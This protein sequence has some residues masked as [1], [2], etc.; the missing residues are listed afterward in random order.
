M[1]D[2]VLDLVNTIVGTLPLEYNFIMPI[3]VLMVSCVILIIPFIPF[4]ILYRIVKR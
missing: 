2:N 4:I 1:I 3:L